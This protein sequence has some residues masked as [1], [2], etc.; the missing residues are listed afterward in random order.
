MSNFSFEL[1]K[2]DGQARRGRIKTPRG[3]I[4][5]PIFMPVGTCGS[6]KAL[7]PD[8]LLAVKAQ[9]ILGNTYHLMLRPGADLLKKMGGLHEFMQWEKPILTDSGGFQVFSLALGKKAGP[10]P[11]PNNFL[12]KI[13]ES[14]VTFRSFIDGSKHR[15]TPE[16]SIN[17]Q[18]C[19]GSDFLMAFDQ[20]PSGQSTREDVKTA[21]TRTTNWL[22]RCIDAQVNKNAELFGIIQGGIYTDLRK[23][24]AREICQ[25][26]LFG[27][28]V[29]GLSVGEKKEDM[30]PACEAITEII[31]HN[32]PR[33]LM[34]VGTPKDLLDG[35]ARGID[36]FD[37]VMPTRN[38]RNGCLFTAVGKI[39]IKQAQHR[40]SDKPLDENCNCYTC[41]TFSRSYLRHLFMSNELLFYRLASLHNLTYYL[42]LIQ[43]ARTSIENGSFNSLVSS[44]EE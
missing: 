34:G 7:G 44:F 18:N 16:D 33:Y 28:A 43:S 11:K 31:P 22:D 40:F 38:A 3:T 32:K 25:R 37:C 1:L 20:C 4:E 21:M 27:F 39:L 24:H 2:T 29:G 8:D 36:M 13:D 19:I 6:V 23:E 5:T 12:V 26:D 30:W 35:I 15:M 41:R 17:I 10:N 9:I 42:Y 14:G